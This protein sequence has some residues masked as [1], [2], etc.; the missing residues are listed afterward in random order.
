MN[1]EILLSLEDLAQRT[2]LPLRTVRYYIQLGLVD[3]P[4]GVGRGARYGRHHLEQLLLVQSMQ[5][6][7]LSLEQIGEFV[8]RDVVATPPALPRAPG[9]VEMWSRL[10][11]QDGVEL[12]VEP[13]RA[14]LSP[15]Q[16]RALYRGVV[17][18]LEHVRR[19][20]K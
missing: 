13:G 5:R 6:R 20:P 11:V 17:E 16:A 3:R 1:D 12:H 10:F 18:L 4:E 2:A 8:R 9:D 19:M 14:G 7:G 15:E